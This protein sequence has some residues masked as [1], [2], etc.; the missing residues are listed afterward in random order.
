VKRIDDA[1]ARAKTENRLALVTYVTCGFPN[2]ES[3]PLIVRSLVEGG[4]DIIELGV[5]FSD[6]VADGATIQK[7]SFRALEAGMTLSGCLDVAALIRRENRVPLVLMTYVNPVLAFGERAFVERAADAGVDG[8][9]LVDVP[10]E[11]GA[12]LRSLC[13]A[14]GIDNIML[15]APSS[16]D[17]RMRRIVAEASGFV[18]CVSVAGVTGAR[19][20]LPPTLPDFLV[21]VRRHTPLPLAIGFGVSK[22]EH[23]RAL[24]GLADAVVVGSA[25]MDIIDAAPP[26]EIEA[27]LRQYVRSL[28]S[29]KEEGAPET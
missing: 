2:A 20:K 21:R 19:S 18:Y 28:A 24:H 12:E 27:R 22:A 11:E 29:Y 13:N 16:D 7:A 14:A 17:E 25:I 26:G 4:A 3:M 1:L 8:L 23:L 6:P 5:P 9:I 15:V 10:P